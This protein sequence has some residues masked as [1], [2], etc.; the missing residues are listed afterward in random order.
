MRF[1]QLTAPSAAKAVEDTAF[2]RSG[3]LLSRND[4]GFEAERF[5]A[6]ATWF[7]N[8]A[9]QRLRDFPDNLLATATHDH[10][11]GED[12]RARLAVLSE[13]GPW[14]ASRVEHWR[15]LATP[16]RQSL[17]DGPAPS[18]ADELLLYQT[19]LGSWPLELDLQDLGALGRYA[20]RVRQWQQKALREAKLRSS[21]SA[22][23]DAYEQ[24]CATY[25]DE[26]LLG[27][28]NQ[29]LRRSLHDAAQHIASAGALNGLA[30]CLLRM[31][32]PGVPDL[33][34]GNEYWDLSLV[35]PDNRRPVDYAVRRASLDDS[36]PLAELLAHWRDGRIKQA[37]IARV[38][39]ARQAHPQLFQ[40]G[41]YLPLTVHGRHA[42]KVLAFAR[43]GEDARA[44]VV[45]PRLCAPCSA[46]PLCP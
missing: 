9:Q 12:C 42:D 24:A 7:H 43:L 32:S 33:Y 2:Y 36:V 31:T 28:Q 26:L 17:N 41:A 10:K 8:E 19:L 40:R 34:Q 4:V 13:H 25:V 6:D 23:N 15:E 18:P 27:P 20:E 30:Q 45:V 46:T 3:R 11:R 39:D 38:L 16:L 14:L 29:Q 5:S 35:D 21:W 1:Q 22:P 37:L 44:I